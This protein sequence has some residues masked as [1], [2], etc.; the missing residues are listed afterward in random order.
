MTH[1]TDHKSLED[2]VVSNAL[3]FDTLYR[4]LVEKGILTETEFDEKLNEVQAYYQGYNGNHQ[5]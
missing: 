2:L 1:E 4:L 3:Q 5:T